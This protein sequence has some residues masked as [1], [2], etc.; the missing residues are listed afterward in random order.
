MDA[1]DTFCRLVRARSAE[2]A[3]A[4][5][6]LASAQLWGQTISI[7]RQELDS[8]IRVIYLLSL[9]DM[10]YRQSLIEASVNGRKWTVKGKNARI[11]D[12]EM[13]ELAG[14]LHGWTASVYKFGCAFIHLSDF[15]DYNSRDPFVRLPANEQ[16]DILHH[17]RNYHFG[18][19]QASPTFQDLTPY[20]PR[21]L[22]KISSNLAHYVEQL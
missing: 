16:N 10:S 11:T 15:H 17:L 12:K 21:V 19:P 3:E 18:P 4:M 22:D 20:F 13:A 9:S 5:H 1:L 8:M 6:L 14:R 7:L 2:N